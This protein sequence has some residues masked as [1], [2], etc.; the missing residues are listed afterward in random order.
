MITF[1]SFFQSLISL[2]INQKILISEIFKNLS[3]TFSSMRVYK[4]TQIL[5]SQ[6]CISYTL[7][8]FSEIES[9]YNPENAN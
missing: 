3:Y 1:L 7:T 6:G 4:F 9:S 2:S 8:V 5:I